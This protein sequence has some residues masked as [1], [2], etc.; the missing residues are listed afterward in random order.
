[1]ESNS[2]VLPATPAE[3]NSAS[4][5]PRVEA[6]SSLPD[7]KSHSEEPLEV[8]GQDSSGYLEGWRLHTLSL[9]FA[10]ESLA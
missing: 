4:E 3:P 5:S 9:W 6:A 10:F 7:E 1:M 2:R 8:F